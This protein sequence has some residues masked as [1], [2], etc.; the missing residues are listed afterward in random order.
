MRSIVI[1]AVAVSMA[2]V[3]LMSGDEPVSAEQTVAQPL[4]KVYRDL[5][6]LYSAIE[7]STAV[8][9]AVVGHPP[10]PVKMTFERDE[11]RM[12]GLTATG[13]FRSAYIKTWI[14]PGANANETHLQVAVWPETMLERAGMGDVHS[15]VEAVLHGT[16]AQLAPGKEIPALFGKPRETDTGH[17]ER[18]QISAS[19][20]SGT[21]EPMMDPTPSANTR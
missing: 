13:G 17:A 8:S 19:V 20:K 12:L 3:Y 1:G 7:R 4:E 5:D 21:T 11:G 2:S 16:E 6:A 10:T 14:E 18:H 9:A 15:A